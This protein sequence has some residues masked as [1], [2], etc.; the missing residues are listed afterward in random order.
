MRVFTNLQIAKLLRSVSAALSLSDGDNRFRIIAYDRAA[1]AIEHSSSEVKDLWDNGKLK[2]LSGVG[3]GIASSLDELFRLGKVKHFYSILR[4][5]PPAMFELMEIPGLGPKNA[6]KLCKALGIIKTH[7]A[8][9][10]LEKAAKSGKIAVLEGFGQESQSNIL[11]NIDGYK[12]RTRRLLLNVAH[13]TV[14]S[15]IIWMNKIPQVKQ[16]NYLGSLRRQASTVG[17]IDIAVATDDPTQVLEHFTQYP[18]KSRVLEAGEHTASIVLPNG[19][20]VD[21]MVQPP[22]SYGSLL[23]HFTGSKHHNI[24]LRE[25]AMKLGYSL[26]EYGIKK[27]S[28]SLKVREGR[29]VSYEFPDEKSFYNF[30]GLD[31]IPPE[32]REARGEI[33]AAKNHTLL[34]LVEI[35]DIKGD[36]HI[37]SNFDIEPSHDLGTSSINQ[38]VEQAVKLGYEYIGLTDHNPSVANHSEKQ[39][40]DLIK[41]RTNFIRNENR[42]IKVF[43]GMEIDLQPDGQRSLPDK[44]LEELDYACVSIH[45]S[46]RQSRKETTQRV[47]HGLDHPK[48]KFLAHPTGRLLQER[49]GVEL[50]WDQIFDFCIRNHKWLEIDA[51]PTRLDLPDVVVHKAIRHG[52]KIII[53]S[54]SHAAGQ[55]PFIKYGVSVARRGWATKTDII[56]TCNLKQIGTYLS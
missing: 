32:L 7:S 41:K 36:L 3:E 2:E 38:I 20:Q 9:S 23:Q 13:G 24:A 47:L 43:N 22:Q 54:D 26:S 4:P 34:H 16:I 18:G 1:D 42:A 55:L 33:E 52:V 29:G 45:S 28:P 11:Q 37:H 27:T 46:F 15:I 56:N 39:M 14:D 5:F 48:V 10:K 44:C 12:N 25:Y 17:D 51:W 40:L 35:G 49:E 30:L 31:F 6:Y 19:C 53:D 8:I 21:L 50:D